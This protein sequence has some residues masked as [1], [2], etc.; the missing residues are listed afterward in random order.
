MRALVLSVV[1]M[2]GVGL[3]ACAKPLEGPPIDLETVAT[4]D[5]VPAAAV[6]VV[7][8]ALGPS[9][10]A[11]EWKAWVPP[12][13]QPN[14]DRVEGH[15]IVIQRTPPAAEVLEPTPVIPRGPKPQFGAKPVRPQ[16]PAPQAGKT[17]VPG[18]REMAAPQ[19]PQMPQTPQT[20]QT[21]K[22]LPF[23][24][25]FSPHGGQMPYATP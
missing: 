18:A 2:C 1:L 19:M 16:A 12:Q 25:P 10:N 17:D 6:P 7:L 22:P 11:G 5:P 4:P 3:V 23:S 13:V 9:A 14:G 21:S 24:M 20:S 15:W 8:P